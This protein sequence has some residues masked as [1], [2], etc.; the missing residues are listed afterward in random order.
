MDLSSTQPF[1]QLYVIYSKEVLNLIVRETTVPH[2]PNVFVREEE[3]TRRKLK[4]RSVQDVLYKGNSSEVCLV[5][6]DNAPPGAPSESHSK[7]QSV[8]F[9]IR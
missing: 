4:G 2:P 3:K 1:K 9:R 6:S 7:P 5:D 8:Q